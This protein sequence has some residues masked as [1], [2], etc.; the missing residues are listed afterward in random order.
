[1]QALNLPFGEAPGP[2]TGS[3]LKAERFSYGSGGDS[4][5]VWPSGLRRRF[6]RSLEVTLPKVRI[7]LLPFQRGMKYIGRLAQP[8]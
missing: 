3:D 6:A 8:V 5:E 1:M 2:A 4:L 7:L